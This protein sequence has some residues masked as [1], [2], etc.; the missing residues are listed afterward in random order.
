MGFD[1][2]HKTQQRDQWGPIF[3]PLE[4]PCEICGAEVGAFC[5]KENRGI[6]VERALDE[7]QKVMIERKRNLKKEGRI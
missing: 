6:H 1:N 5:D 7:L 3:D 2:E 4:Y